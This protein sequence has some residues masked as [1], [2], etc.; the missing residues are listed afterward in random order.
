MEENKKTVKETINEKLASG[1]TRVKAIGGK[2]W[3]VG[4]KVLPVAGAFAAG[5]GVSKLVNRPAS[6]SHDY[7]DEFDDPGFEA[8]IG[9]E[10]DSDSTESETTDAN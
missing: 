6:E 2:I 10:T 3:S 8:L 7:S 9:S 4:K 1:K 5:Y